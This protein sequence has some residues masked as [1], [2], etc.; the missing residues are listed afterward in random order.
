[1]TDKENPIDQKSEFDT[2]LLETLNRIFQDYH[3]A[4]NEFNDAKK[5]VNRL[6]CVQ[7]NRQPV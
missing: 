5:N 2:E 3:I 4:M 6:I 7:N 1:M